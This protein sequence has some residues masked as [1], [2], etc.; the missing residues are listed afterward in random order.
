MGNTLY[1]VGYDPK[2]A[3]QLWETNGTPGNATRITSGNAKNGGLNPSNLAEVGTTLFFTANDGTHGNQLWQSAGTTATT[4][5]IT[6]LNPSN[7][8]ITASDLTVMNGTLYFA[9]DDGT[10]GTQL[11]Q[12][13][14]TAAGTTMVADINGNSTANVSALMPIPSILY[15]DAWTTAARLAGLPERRHAG[16]DRDGTTHPRHR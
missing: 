14:G 11:W 6:D 4:T 16:R 8:G 3:Y 10:D 9:G 1:F 7:G 15:F 2:N 13:N 5:M 12:S